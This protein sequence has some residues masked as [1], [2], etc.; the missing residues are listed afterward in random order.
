[1]FSLVQAAC[2]L[3]YAA[4]L[5][6]KGE[7]SNVFSITKISYFRNDIYP[8][9]TK[10]QAFMHL[11]VEHS[12]RR[13]PLVLLKNLV[14]LVLLCPFADVCAQQ[15]P[16]NVILL[17]DSLIQQRT[18]LLNR[19][20]EETKNDTAKV[21]L[22][23]EL[24]FFNIEGN[25]KEAW[26]QVEE[27]KELAKLHGDDVLQAQCAQGLGYFQTLLGNYEASLVFYTEA[28]DLLQNASL[29]YVSERFIEHLGNVSNAQARSIVHVDVLRNRSFLFSE[30]GN[31]DQRK[32][33]LQLAMRLAQENE[34]E[35]RTWSCHNNLGWTYMHMNQ[36]D[37][38]YMHWQEANSYL[39][40]NLS[41]GTQNPSSELGTVWLGGVVLNAKGELKKSQLLFKRAWDLLSTLKNISRYKPIVANDIATYHLSTNNADSVIHYAKMAIEIS[42][43][44]QFIPKEKAEGYLNLSYGLALKDQIDSAYYYQKLGQSMLDSLNFIKAE[45]VSKFH[46]AILNQNIENQAAET[47]RLTTRSRRRTYA[48]AFGIGLLSIIGLLQYRNIRQKQKSNEI[49]GEQKKDLETTLIQL[50]S[51]QNQLIQ[52]EKMASLGELTAGIAHE[53]QNPLNFVNNFSEVSSELVDEVVDTL[54]SSPLSEQKADEA[55]DVLNNLKNNLEKI[56]HHGG[57]ASG[58]VKGMLD[59]SRSSSG[60]KELT[61]INVLADEYLRLSYHGLRAKD[62]SFNCAFETNLDDKLPKLE[63][64]PQDLGRVLLNVFSNAFYACAERSRSACA[65]RSKSGLSTRP[66]PQALAAGS[67]LKDQG[68]YSP[69]VKVSTQQSNNSTT[70]TISD[71]GIGMSKETLEKIFQPFYTTKPTGSGTGLGM[72]ISYDI[73]TKGHGGEIRIESKEGEGTI[74]IIILPKD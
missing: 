72:S 24:I 71:N 26:A 32:A 57:R 46:S 58:I 25:I 13:Q 68:I 11:K 15:L 65:E 50:K 53:I 43:E 10:R 54:T 52:S 64:I 21:A 31:W 2:P 59:H 1:M 34:D 18:E 69:I 51:T 73:I 6:K 61:D 44:L 39:D 14:V 66:T 56:V 37:S 70:I 45:N 28:M 33:D 41:V 17:E 38:A 4:F 7:Y 49:L 47:E 42:T 16:L 30:V 63:V 20:L 23:M 27:L 36:I 62:K 5:M 55:K 3:G 35:L 60:E 19:Q 40:K 12:S 29:E 67:P 48:L 9:G 22:L 74:V 8:F